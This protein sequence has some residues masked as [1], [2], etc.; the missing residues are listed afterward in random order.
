MTKRINQDPIILAF[1]TSNPYCAAAL[2][3]KGAIQTTRTD[4]MSKGQAEHLMPMLETMLTDAGQSWQTLDA[5]AVGVG[6]GNFTGIRISV[7]A[8]RG[9]VLGLGIPAIGVTN[10]Q[11]MGYMKSKKGTLVSL[12]GPRDTAFVKSSE[13]GIPIQIDPANA[14]KDLQLPDMH[15][16]GHQAKDIAAQFQASFDE[17]DMPPVAETIAW[18]ANSRW[19]NGESFDRPKPL[20]VRAADAA[21]PKTS[22]PIILP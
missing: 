7:S 12:P 9:L 15:V 18:I 5:I 14:P 22:A 19:Q 21:P 1:D 11:V 6:P 8:A 10:F 4:P 16:V 3:A 2:L 13:D 17:C 20:Y